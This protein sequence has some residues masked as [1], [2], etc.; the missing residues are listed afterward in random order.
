MYT[1]Q[2]INSCYS[3]RS[4]IKC[5]NI[6]TNEISNV[7]VFEITPDV[8]EA[9]SADYNNFIPIIHNIIAGITN[10]FILIKKNSITENE[11]FDD[12]YVSS[13]HHLFM[14]GHEIFAKNIKRA[15][16][17]EVKPEM[18]YSICTKKCQAIMING[19]E[20]MTW[21]H[22][23][24]LDYSLRKNIYWYRNIDLTINQKNNIV[25]AK[26]IM[27]SSNSLVT[28]HNE[29]TLKNYIANTIINLFH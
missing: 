22:D 4:K 1:N 18:L 20:V 8:Y 17:V 6:I 7:P 27:S 26:K 23:D 21:S 19:L 25:D 12:F 16:K 14:N 10:R 2:T 5:R 11:P 28:S 15:K 3:G 24:W 9:Y 29:N 13:K